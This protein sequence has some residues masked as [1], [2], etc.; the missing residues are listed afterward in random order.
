MGDIFS[1]AQQVV[2]VLGSPSDATDSVLDPSNWHE[3]VNFNAS[4]FMGLVQIASH[5]YWTR[6]WVLQEVAFAKV[7][8]IS[9]GSHML[10]ADVLLGK[11]NSPRVILPSIIGSGRRSTKPHFLDLLLETH[12]FGGCR[13]ARD[14]LYSR[15][16]LAH[17]GRLLIPNLDYTMPVDAVYQE[18]AAECIVR[19]DDLNILGF[20]RST[21]MNLPSWAPDW[22]S[23]VHDCDSLADE[24][25]F[26]TDDIS[27]SNPILNMSQDHRELLVTGR[28]L[29]VIIYPMDDEVRADKPR[30]GDWLCL[31]YR[32]PTVVF[33]RRVGDC[34][35]IVGGRRVWQKW[36]LNH[37]LTG[38]ISYKHSGEDQTRRWHFDDPGAVQRYKQRIFRIR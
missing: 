8:M 23:W 22:A 19:C 17:N 4:M 1:R 28:M 24:I 18:F 21:T 27:W 11:T 3:N 35:R 7:S 20:V 16:P 14:L 15:L 34:Y 6:S 36:A 12:G 5:K 2:S 29:R 31:L 38:A 13:D 37:Y 9:C 33:L 25:R 32:C 30:I 10:L 26:N